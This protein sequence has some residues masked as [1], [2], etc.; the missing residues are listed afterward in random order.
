MQQ[1]KLVRPVL[2]KEIHQGQRALLLSADSEM[3]SGLFVPLEAEIKRTNE[4]NLLTLKYIIRVHTLLQIPET[5]SLSCQM[6]CWF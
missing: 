4:A 2:T 5:L 3:K 6:F 1:A